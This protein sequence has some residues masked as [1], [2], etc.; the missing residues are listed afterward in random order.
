[1]FVGLG[2]NAKPVHADIRW[3]SGIVQ[4]LSDLNP[5]QYHHLVEPASPVSSNKP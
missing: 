2:P 1:V 5:R 4:H 3:P